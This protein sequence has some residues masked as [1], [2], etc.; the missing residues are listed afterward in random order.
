MVRMGNQGTHEV[1]KTWGYYTDD[2]LDSRNVHATY[3]RP[4]YGS[5]NAIDSDRD[6]GTYQNDIWI[7][8]GNF[9]SLRNVEVGYSLPKRL[10]AKA[11]L[12]KCRLYFSGYNLCTWSSVPDGCDPEKPMSYV[13]WYPKTRTFTF[14][15]N[16]G[17]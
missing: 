17:F 15:I 3:P 5:Y 10:I 16:I 14:G 6:T 12:T 11:N 13:W 2:P 4:T 7:V 8:N 9:L 1:V